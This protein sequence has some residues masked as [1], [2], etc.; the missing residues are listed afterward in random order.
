MKLRIT[1]GTAALAGVTLVGLAG[2]GSINAAASAAMSPEASA[3][4]SVGFDPGDLLPVSDPTPSATASGAAHARAA[5][6]HPAQRRL[7][8]RRALAR[9][10]MHGEVVVKTKQGDRTID[11]QRGT[12]TAITATTVSV[13]CTDGFTETWTFGK[14]IR[15]IEHR[16]SVQ[17][18][19]VAPGDKV[20]VAG[21]KAGAALTASLLVI[22]KS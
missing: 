10:V 3:L 17:P 18:S 13:K 14:P 19:A 22:P 12:V 4:T 7:T 2:C 20:G 9:N 1:L 5:G 15:V 8:I 6:R 11:V 16:T 21:T